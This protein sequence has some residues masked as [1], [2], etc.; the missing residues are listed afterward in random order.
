MCN[1]SFLRWLQSSI[2]DNYDKLI[3]KSFRD[4]GL[5]IFGFFSHWSIGLCFQVKEQHIYIYIYR[6]IYIYIYITM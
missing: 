3:T 6:V 2:L 5:R 4:P 1:F